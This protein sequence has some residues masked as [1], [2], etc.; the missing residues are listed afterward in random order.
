MF[1]QI[2]FKLNV[3]LSWNCASQ[4]FHKMKSNIIKAEFD[5]KQW[6][7]MN[8]KRVSG[9]FGYDFKT[10]QEH[11]KEDYRGDYRVDSH[12]TAS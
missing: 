6:P 2:I 8:K 7:E 11:S 4:K 10:F 12:Q 9:L 1:L 3:E 5:Y